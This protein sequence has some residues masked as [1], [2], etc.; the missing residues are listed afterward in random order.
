VN[1]G[2]A[3]EDPGRGGGL[4]VAGKRHAARGK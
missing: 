3:G 2:A 4:S 1:G